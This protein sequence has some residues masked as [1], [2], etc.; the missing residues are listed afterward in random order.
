MCAPGARADRAIARERKKDQPEDPDEP[1][2]KDDGWR[3]VDTQ[4]FWIGEAVDGIGHHDGA[5]EYKVDVPI[6]DFGDKFFFAGGQARW[7]EVNGGDPAKTY[8]LPLVQ[9]A[10]G[11]NVSF[12]VPVRPQGACGL[13][14]MLAG[15]EVRAAAA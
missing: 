8:R 11:G 10:A 12:R 7:T 9:P 15:L 14:C 3:K 5:C 13:V 4:L 6:E 1:D 2:D